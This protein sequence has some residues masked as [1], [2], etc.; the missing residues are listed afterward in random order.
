MAFQ[1][2]ADCSFLGAEVRLTNP[3]SAK[4]IL[5]YVQRIFREFL[6][7]HRCKFGFET[8]GSYACHSL[9]DV[10][11]LQAHITAYIK[12]RFTLDSPQWRCLLSSATSEPKLY[13]VVS[14]TST[15]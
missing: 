2:E 11:G 4:H 14:T 12:F 13:Q 1:R 8:T 9:H 3:G 5:V 10:H 6:A 7:G 15:L